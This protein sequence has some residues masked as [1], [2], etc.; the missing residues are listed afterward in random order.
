MDIGP[1]TGA[2]HLDLFLTAETG[3][4]VTSTEPT[5]VENSY[6]FMK[7]LFLRKMR[8]AVNGSEHS[9]LKDALHRLF[10]NNWAQRVKTISDILQQLKM[11]DPQNGT[12]L[13]ELMGGM[14]IGIIVNSAS[15][16][17]DPGFGPSMERACADYFGVD[18]RHIGDIGSDASVPESVKLKKP[19]VLHAPESEASRAL[20]KCFSKLV[21]SDE[22]I[23]DRPSKGMVV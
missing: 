4:I 3:L 5:S 6:R 11:M 8:N 1:G 20:K 2:S 13:D 22:R 21:S 12:L 19:L 16:A 7:C 15:G 18:I 10:T 14:K 23:S 9:V 17:V